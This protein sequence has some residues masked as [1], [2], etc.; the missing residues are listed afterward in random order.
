MRFLALAADYDGTLATDGRVGET[1]I[2]ALKRLISSGRKLVLVTGR[3]LPELLDVFPEIDLCERV[4]AENGAV[5]YR[6]ATKDMHLL[7]ASPPPRFIEELQRRG[8]RHLSVGQVVVATRTPYETVVLDVIRD[9]GLE[10]RIVFNK[11]AV[12][13]LPTNVDKASGLAAVL[14][15]LELSPHNIV[16]VGDGE[17]D[18]ALLRLPHYAVTVANAVPMLKEAADLVTTGDHGTGVEELIADLV[19]HD[20]DP[21]AFSPPRH[22]IPLGLRED[23]QEVS[24]APFGRNLLIAGTSGSGKST[25]ATGFLERLNG[26]GY[27]FCIIDPEGDYEGF[28]DA[29]VFGSA[30]RGPSVNEILT[31][32]AKP[33]NPVVVNLVGLPLQDRPSFFLE[34]L[35]RLQE[36]RTK[37]G[38]PHW[39]LVDET[40]HQMPVDR[41]ATTLVQAQ[42]LSE[43]IYVTVHPDQI[44]RSVVGTADMIIALGE[45]PA[46]TIIGFCEAIG[47]A[48]PTVEETKL[49]PGE[50]LV[51]ERLGGGGPYK[52][53]I[54]PGEAE[55]RRHRRKYA[56]GALPADRSFYFRG[57]TGALNLRAQNLI[58]FAQLADGVDEATW[59]HHLRR[60]DYSRWFEES[61]KDDALAE[62]ARHIE[63]QSQLSADEGR[64]LMRAAIEAHY[65]MPARE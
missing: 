17:N 32:L 15:E 22:R 27:Q 31:A 7:G 13:V 5:L 40:H 42:N 3:V 48:A 57:P 51:W 28:A 36:L 43:M 4:V 34:L 8:V 56:E 18:H 58:L 12:M 39:L 64:K 25:L 45:A 62:A 35:P 26:G 63:R 16:A 21:A 50:A 49:L 55:R 9:L 6:P 10:L 24:I 37:T 54:T 47:E 33:G 29:I 20:L 59:A 65:T 60:G 46:R 44:E 23:G 53:R 11:G 14:D 1:T 2:A 19:D 30:E 41:D 61:I 52:M 38:R